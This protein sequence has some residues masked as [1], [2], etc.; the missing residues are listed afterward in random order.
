MKPIGALSRWSWK[1]EAGLK[2]CTPFCCWFDRAGAVREPGLVV[3]QAQGSVAVQ[4][5]I[6]GGR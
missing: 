5:V 1:R 4:A 3:S 6:V 2:A